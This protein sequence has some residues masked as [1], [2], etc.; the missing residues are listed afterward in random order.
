MLNEALKALSAK[1]T[2]ET[3]E[4]TTPTVANLN[5]G[6]APGVFLATAK[7]ALR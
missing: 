7:S 6:S 3:K 2:S 4:T 5:T 1:K